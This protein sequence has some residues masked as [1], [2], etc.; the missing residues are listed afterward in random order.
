MLSLKIVIV[1]IALIQVTSAIRCWQYEDQ[2]GKV[3]VQG[4]QK[5]DGQCCIRVGVAAFRPVTFAQLSLVTTPLMVN[6]TNTTIHTDV[7]R[8]I[9]HAMG[10][11]R[12][13][14]LWH[15]VRPARLLQRRV[16]LRRSRPVQH[17]RHHDI[18]VDP[19]HNTT[20]HVLCTFCYVNMI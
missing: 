11:D 18:P 15:A 19:V 7:L 17:G 8:Q 9:G 6:H 20:L 4:K 2:D 1:I 13:A 3:N 14:Y 10:H 12:A 16:H 5:C